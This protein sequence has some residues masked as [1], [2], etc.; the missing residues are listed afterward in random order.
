M[1]LSNSA[2]AP[3]RTTPSRSFA[4]W[5]SAA[6]RGRR[7]FVALAALVL[8][9]G[10]ALNWT[11]LVAAGVA[12]LLVSALPCVAMCALGLCMKRMAGRHDKASPAIR[13][14]TEFEP[15]S[16]GPSGSCCSSGQEGTATAVER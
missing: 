10:A 3:P 2:E 8:V 7:R 6:V 1:N 14:E 13:P 16:I 15:L 9:L 4:A 11:W 12:P 5:L